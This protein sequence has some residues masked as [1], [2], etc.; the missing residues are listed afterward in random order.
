MRAFYIFFLLCTKSTQSHAFI[1]DEQERREYTSCTQLFGIIQI[2]IILYNLWWIFFSVWF[3]L[4]W[5]VFYSYSF[6]VLPSFSV[7]ICEKKGKKIHEKYWAFNRQKSGVEVRMKEN[8]H[9]AGKSSTLR[10]MCADRAK[11]NEK[12]THHCPTETAIGLTIELS[13]KKANEKS[14]RKKKL[15]HNILIEYHFWIGFCSVSSLLRARLF[16]LWYEHRR[17]TNFS[18]ECSFILF[19]RSFCLLKSH[20]SR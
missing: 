6:C 5:P 2:I 3:G 8:C 17:G 14:K 7:R 1:E 11:E 20:D 16:E 4:V 9:D 19:T 15:F 12:R 18:R 10:N 13:E